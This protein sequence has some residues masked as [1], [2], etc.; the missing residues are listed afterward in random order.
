VNIQ[1][2]NLGTVPNDRTG[3]TIRGGG[4]KIN[5][6]F[7]E[8]FFYGPA[9]H[10]QSALV[11]KTTNGAPDFLSYSGLDVTL[12]GPFLGSIAGLNDDRGERNVAVFVPSVAANAWTVQNSGDTWIWIGTTPFNGGYT[13]GTTV[14]EPATQQ[15]APSQTVGRYWYDTLTGSVKTWNGSAWVQVYV[16]FLA[17]VSSNA[18]SITSLTYLLDNDETLMARAE[19][20]KAAIVLG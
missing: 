4:A 5:S 7:Q 20:T 13:F 9:R 19:A 15:S 10:R 17:K 12:T 14:L 8:L 18:G 2:L 11:Y 1:L 6:N 3:D 16:L